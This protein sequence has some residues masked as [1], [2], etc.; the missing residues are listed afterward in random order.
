M[1]YYIKENNL[2]KRFIQIYKLIKEL[3]YNLDKLQNHNFKKINVDKIASSCY[4]YIN[5]KLKIVVKQ[6][7][8]MGEINNT[9]TD[10]VQT[11][12]FKN[13]NKQNSDF[14]HIFIQPLVEVD[15][16]S[17]IKAMYLLENKIEYGNNKI[18]MHDNNT[19][20]FLNKPVLIDF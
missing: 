6:P 2:I 14:Q 17:R 8:I 5:E 7:Y 13:P 10:L 4:I 15:Y 12:I 20:I 18:D 3:D 11:L 16:D 19:G 1:K 9:P